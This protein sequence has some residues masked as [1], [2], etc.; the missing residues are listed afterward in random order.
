[1]EDHLHH[2]LQLYMRYS[3]TLMS[4]NRSDII[5]EGREFG[6]M[7]ISTTMEYWA[8]Q[9]RILRIGSVSV[10]PGNGLLFH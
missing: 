4:Q 1:M 9:N 7:T 3:I 8:N 2:D 6:F 10:L 5:I